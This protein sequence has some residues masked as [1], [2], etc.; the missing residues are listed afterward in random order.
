MILSEAVGPLHSVIG[1]A[2]CL[3]KVPR[4]KPVGQEIPGT[5]GHMVE[6]PRKQGCLCRREAKG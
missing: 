3:R 5:L 6:A 4:L 1:L 2:G